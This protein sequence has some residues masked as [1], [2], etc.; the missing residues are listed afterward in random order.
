MFDL[1]SLLYKFMNNTNYFIRFAKCKS[2]LHI[3]DLA[4]V[5]DGGCHHPILRHVRGD[6]AFGVRHHAAD[7]HI[8]AELILDQSLDRLDL[9]GLVKF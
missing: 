7:V 5:L 3:H 8:H 2:I 6:L 4:A 9:V 1:R